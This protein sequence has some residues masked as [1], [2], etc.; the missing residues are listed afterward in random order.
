MRVN[1]G[2]TIHHKNVFMRTLVVIFFVILC[3]PLVSQEINPLNDGDFKE[4]IIGKPENYDLTTLRTY[5]DDAD[6][7]LEMG[8]Q[9]LMVQEIAWPQVRLKVEIYQMNSPEGAFGVYTLSKSK[10]VYQD[11]LAARDCAGQFQYLAAHG[12]LYISVT[13]ETGSLISQAHYLEVAEKIIFK[14]RQT[15]F[16]LPEPFN[17]PRF[18]KGNNNLVYLN[19]PVSLQNSLFP[20]Q[21]IFLGVRFSM[22]AITLAQPDND[23]WF[24]RIHFEEQQDMMRFLTLAGLTV[25]DVPVSN[26]NTNDG[27][28]REYKDL[29]NLTIYFLQSQEPWPI[30]ELI[31]P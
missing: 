29:G 28:Y 9:S 26:T 1:F 21:D 19:G 3:K 7:F 5:S 12:S 17:L 13:S 23:I 4:S 22:Y 8:F 14:N 27:I 24:A 10:C 6:I 15:Q 11:T 16:I 25:N 20:W 2:G 18:V 31:K 30:D